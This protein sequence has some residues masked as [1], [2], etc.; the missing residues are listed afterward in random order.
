M[1]GLVAVFHIGGPPIEQDDHKLRWPCFLPYWQTS[2]YYK[3]IACH[4][5]CYV[6]HSRVSA[7]SKWFDQ[8]CVQK[9]WEFN[10][11]II[12]L[13]RYQVVITKWWLQVRWKEVL[14]TWNCAPLWLFITLHPMPECGIIIVKWFL[15]PRNTQVSACWLLINHFVFSENTEAFVRFVPDN[16]GCHSVMVHCLQ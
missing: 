4:V 10:K 9:K 3:E 2:L 16:F 11:T 1:I 5:K 13:V 7:Q 12:P 6:R 14:K 15:P 8:K